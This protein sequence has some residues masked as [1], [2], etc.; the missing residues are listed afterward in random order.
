MDSVR[1]L[2]VDDHPVFRF[3]LRTLLQAT[4]DI[5]VVGEAATGREAIALAAR[6]QPDVVL[7][8]LQLPDINGIEVTRQ[9]LQQHPK[10]GILIITMFEDSDSVFAAMRVGALGYILKGAEGDDM[11]RAIRAVA[12]GEAIFSPTIA[13][14]LM[15]HFATPRP[16]TD[17]P[18]PELTEREREVLGLIAQG[19]T[20]SA[21]AQ[22]LQLR[23]KTV[24]NFVSSIFSKL[25]VSH[26]S[27]AIVRAREAGLGNEAHP[28]V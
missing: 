1:L 9:I 5:A 8:D 23:P 15:R 2:T 20:N 11:L 17:L 12:R 19:L 14:R 21:I 10:L 27:E 3:G 6:L 24:R 4:T 13:Q 22:Q 28:P 26:R 18:F 16:V 7:M 25:Q